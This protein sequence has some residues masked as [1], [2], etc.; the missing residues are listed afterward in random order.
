MQ[1][2]SCPNKGSNAFRMEL[3]IPH[4]TIV[5]IATTVYGNALSTMIHS[6]KVYIL[7]SWLT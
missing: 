4:A 1:T 5:R 7:S 3:L 2:C 6:A